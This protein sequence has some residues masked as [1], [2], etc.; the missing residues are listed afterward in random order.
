MPARGKRDGEDQCS[1]RFQAAAGFVEKLA[2]VRHVFEG[3]GGQHNIHGPILNRPGQALEIGGFRHLV[4][5]PLAGFRDVDA[6]IGHARPQQAAVGLRAAADIRATATRDSR[7]MVADARAQAAAIEAA[8]RKQAAEI[9]ANAYALDPELYRTLRELDTLQQVVGGN[10]R[11]V[12]TLLA[13]IAGSVLGTAHMPW[14]SA[15]PALEPMS[16]VTLWGPATALAVS[17][18]AFAAIAALTVVVERRRS[19]AAIEPAPRTSRV[20]WMRGPWP[21]AAGVGAEALAA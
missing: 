11:M 12:V 4:A 8:A 19:V 14:W 10:T 20:R 7:E 16:I 13:F 1:I 18:I 21:L 2:G 3:L 17:L 5:K 6:A 9:Q 15:R